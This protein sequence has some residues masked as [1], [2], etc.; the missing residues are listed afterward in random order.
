MTCW[1]PSCHVRALPGELW[2][3]AHL[4]EHERQV[5]EGKAR[6]ARAIADKGP[7]QELERIEETYHER[8]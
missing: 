2:C 8:A 5:A 3:H 1:S 4:V 6:I 7:L